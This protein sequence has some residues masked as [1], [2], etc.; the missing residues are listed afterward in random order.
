MEHLSAEDKH[1]RNDLIAHLEHIQASGYSKKE[2][3][4]QL[5][6]EV[7]FTHLNRLCAYKILETRGYI[8]ESVSRGIRSNGFLR[9]CADHPEDE[10]LLPGNRMRPTVTISGGLGK[11]ERRDWRPLLSHRSG[12]PSLSAATDYRCGDGRVECRAAR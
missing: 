5:V 6:R 4:G 9:Y 7:A 3:A 1:F 11:P 8:R 10:Q 2:A 12:K